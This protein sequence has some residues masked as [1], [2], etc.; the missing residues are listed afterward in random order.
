MGQLHLF[1]Q[2]KDRPVTT[3]DADAVRARLD[4]LLGELRTADSMPWS[5]DALD[6]ALLLIPQMTNWLPEA[7]A[8]RVRS[9]F[10][11]HVDRL[12]GK[13]TLRQAD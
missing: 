12:T 8:I 5:K 11:E 7:E 9:E 1:P 4:S 13:A 6:E 10:F 3:P 2:R